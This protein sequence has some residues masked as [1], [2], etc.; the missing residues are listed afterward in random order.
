MATDDAN[1]ERRRAERTNVEV[2]GKVAS[3]GESG[4]ATLCD[5]SPS[6]AAVDTDLNLNADD[7]VEFS[8]GSGELLVGR[9][10]RSHDSGFAFK[11]GTGPEGGEAD[12]ELFHHLYNPQQ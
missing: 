10:V 5:I 9:V 1:S 6:G 2:E 11:F 4:A 7:E 12:D 3:K 8:T